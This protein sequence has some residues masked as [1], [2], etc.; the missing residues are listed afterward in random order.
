MVFI[1]G[2]AY[3]GK[4][5]YAKKYI[6]EGYQIIYD[7][8]LIVKEQLNNRKDPIDELEKLLED[9]KD[10]LDRIV[11]VSDDLGSG[12]V[13]M[14]KELREYREMSG[15]VNCILAKRSEEVIR[16]ISGIGTKIK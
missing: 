15:R 13:P 4:S 5:E 2:G 6:N 3:Q 16:V 1:V 10:R 12:L 8:N 11:V 7:Y 9:L 14:G